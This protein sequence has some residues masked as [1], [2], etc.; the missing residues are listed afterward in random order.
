MEAGV[1]EKFASYMCD[2]RDTPYREDLHGVERK[3]SYVL[4]SHKCSISTVLGFEQ[5]SHILPPS[6]TINYFRIQNLSQK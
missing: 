1:L 4:T 5:T 2:V 3:N 6:Q